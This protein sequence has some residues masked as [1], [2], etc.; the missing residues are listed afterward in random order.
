VFD[1]IGDATNRVALQISDAVTFNVP[2]S[3]GGLILEGTY[4]IVEAGG[5]TAYY[6]DAGYKAQTTSSTT[7]NINPYIP[8]FST[9]SGLIR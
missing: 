6:I 5:V 7:D 3:I 8:Q 9:T 4:P 2:V 1:A